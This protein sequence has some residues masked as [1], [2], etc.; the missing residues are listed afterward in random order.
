MKHWLGVIWSCVGLCAQLN[1]QTYSCELV[2]TIQQ[3]TQGISVDKLSQLYAWS[4]HNV[5]KYDILG[6]KIFQFSEN[7]I[8]DWTQV[9]VTNPFL[10]MAYSE[11]YA[12]GVLLDR[13]LSELHR[14][15]LMGASEGSPLPAVGLGSDNNLWIYN[16]N[17]F[18][19][20]K[21]D[22]MG[23][24][25]RQSPDLSLLL[26]NKTFQP[27]SIQEYE[28]HLYLNDPRYGVFIFD[29]FGNFMQMVLIPNNAHIYLHNQQIFYLEA[30]KLWAYS[31]RFH[32]VFPI[33]L[34]IDL[35]NVLQ[36]CIQ[37]D[38]IW[39]RFSDKIECFALKNG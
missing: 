5:S 4:G 15:D 17:T 14:F 27:V 20:Q 34:P 21:L 36:I 38:H 18:T 39:L 22:K 16:L 6:K 13:T 33:E 30:G 24:V 2:Y 9:D 35:Q 37:Q 8:G 7:R 12:Q 29:A 19:I 25:I 1:A 10:V 3:P 26:T 28:N 31:L 23:Q 32:D 11:P